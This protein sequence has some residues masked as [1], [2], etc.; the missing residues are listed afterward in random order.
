MLKLKIL[1]AIKFIGSNKKRTDIE[2]LHDQLFISNAFN[3]EK[4]LIDKV[5]HNTSVFNKIDPCCTLFISSDLR[6]NWR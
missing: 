1:S 3:L 5:L 6:K 4:S 2:S